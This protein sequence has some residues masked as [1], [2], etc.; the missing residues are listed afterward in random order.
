MS[1]LVRWNTAGGIAHWHVAGGTAEEVA[2]WVIREGTEAGV[3]LHGVARR[4]LIIKVDANE[5]AT[6]FCEP[7][8][9]SERKPASVFLWP[10]ETCTEKPSH[11]GERRRPAC[12]PW[13]ALSDSGSHPTSN[14]LW[15]RRGWYARLPCCLRFHMFQ[16]LKRH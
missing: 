3:V 11:R 8:D 12:R 13:S 16:L 5:D 1:R 9:C 6:T 10:P 14:L 2:S 7:S 15:Y 4:V